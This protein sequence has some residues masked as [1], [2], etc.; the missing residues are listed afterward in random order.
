VPATGA[1]RRKAAYFIYTTIGFI[2]RLPRRYPEAPVTKGQRIII[3]IYVGVLVLCAALLVAAE[4][5]G[6]VT[7][8]SLLPLASEGFKTVLAALVGA[9]STLLGVQHAQKGR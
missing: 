7:R 5:V 4:F 2:A 3:A 8:Q 9:L 6:P 1:I